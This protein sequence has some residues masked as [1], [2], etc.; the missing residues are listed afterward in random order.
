MKKWQ[1]ERASKSLDD[2]RT[3]KTLKW[4][5]PKSGLEIRCVDIVYQDFPTVEWTV[6]FKNI[7]TADTSIL[8]N[9][10]ALDARFERGDTVNR[11]R[12]NGAWKMIEGYGKANHFD[13]GEFV[14]HH[15]IG[16]YAGFGEYQPLKTILDDGV[17]KRLSA[18][19]GRPTEGDIPSCNFG[20]ATASARRTSG[21]AG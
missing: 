18:F 6:Y 8:S 3:Q 9:I 10:Q 19:I 15:A 21:D 7:G 17:T 14:L 2:R 4:T 11:W 5:D 13:T 20:A 12:E 16:S 1:F